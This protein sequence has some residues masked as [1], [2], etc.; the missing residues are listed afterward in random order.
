VVILLSV[1]VENPGLL[2]VKL[3][4]KKQE[5]LKDYKICKAT[6]HRFFTLKLKKGNS[7]FTL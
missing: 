5:L 2:M 4:L 1:G 7:I 3:E 6:Y